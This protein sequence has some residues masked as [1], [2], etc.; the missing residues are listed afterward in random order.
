MDARHSDLTSNYTF[1]MVCANK[2]TRRS[3]EPEASK[4]ALAAAPRK[5]KRVI[6]S[7]FPPFP[8]KARES[9]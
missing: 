5:K 6:R 8:R 4:R 9:C 3:M 1:V 7:R 2:D